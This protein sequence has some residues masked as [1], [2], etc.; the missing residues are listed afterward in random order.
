[1]IHQ[2]GLMNVTG[3]EAAK[4]EAIRSDDFTVINL[5]PLMAANEETGEV[6]WKDSTGQ[7][8]S[9]NL[10][11]HAVRIVHRSPYRRHR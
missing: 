8:R 11:P 1:M 4:Y 6:W 10:G 5:G 3:D 7:E 2:W 9:I